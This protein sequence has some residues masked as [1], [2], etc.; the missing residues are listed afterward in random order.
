MVGFRKLASAARYFLAVSFKTN[1]KKTFQDV[2][3][4]KGM[5]MCDIPRGH[6]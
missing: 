2:L 3:S 6:V 5:T 1:L 4:V